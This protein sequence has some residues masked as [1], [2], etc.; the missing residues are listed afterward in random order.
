MAL[1]SITASDSGY[2]SEPT[3]GANLWDHMKGVNPAMVEKRSS[4]IYTRGPEQMAVY[5]S[6]LACRVTISYQ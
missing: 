3:V 5:D 2:G 4:R 1:D 6:L